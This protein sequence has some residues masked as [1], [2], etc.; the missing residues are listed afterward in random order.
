[1]PSYREPT[2]EARAR[3]AAAARKQALSTFRDNPARDP[4]AVEARQALLREREEARAARAEEKARLRAIRE[5]EEAEQKAAREREA[6]LLAEAK[7]AEAVEL[8]ARQ[9][10]ARDARYSARKARAR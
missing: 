1:M 4:A 10:A 8:A 6:A 3:Q 2:H 7:A 9:K 5:A